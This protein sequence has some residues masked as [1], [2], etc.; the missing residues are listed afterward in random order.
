MTTQDQRLTREEE[1]KHPTNVNMTNHLLLCQMFSQQVCV[2]EMCDDRVQISMNDMFRSAAAP[3]NQQMSDHDGRDGT[4]VRI[5]NGMGVWSPQPCPTSTLAEP[6]M[7]VAPPC[8][9]NL[10]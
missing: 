10:V 5:K 1:A 7:R 4:N 6:M 3:P 9:V 2:R 8:E